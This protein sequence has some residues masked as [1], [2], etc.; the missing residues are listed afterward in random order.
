MNCSS[1]AARNPALVAGRSF[2]L[3][4]SGHWSVQSLASILIST[5]LENLL[6]DLECGDEENGVGLGEDRSKGPDIGI[7][8]VG[9]EEINIYEE[10]MSGGERFNSQVTGQIDRIDGSGEVAIDPVGRVSD[11]VSS[12]LLVWILLR[13]IEREYDLLVQERLQFRVQ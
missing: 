9:G 13:H 11:I 12:E 8:G 3:L 7:D 6:V 4:V 1:I 5:L 2:H 10:I